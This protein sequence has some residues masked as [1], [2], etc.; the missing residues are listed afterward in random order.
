MTVS[1]GATTL[2]S[3]LALLIQ[4]EAIKD[5]PIL[6][7][8]D[9]LTGSGKTTLAENLENHFLRAGTPASTCRYTGVYDIRRSLSQ[10]TLG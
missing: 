4:D 3:D 5:R 7:G 9:G 6:V 10:S 2:C 1:N 8:I